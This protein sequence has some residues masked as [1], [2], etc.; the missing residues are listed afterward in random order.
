MHELVGTAES[1]GFVIVPGSDSAPYALDERRPSA[2][3]LI[4]RLL[5]DD[6][7]R[8]LYHL[9]SSPSHSRP[10]GL[11]HSITVGPQPLIGPRVGTL[12]LTERDATMLTSACLMAIGLAVDTLIAMNGWQEDV[13]ARNFHPRS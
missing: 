1:F 5:T 2:T 8:I 4:Q 9:M 7:G 3:A 6:L 10:D 13:V 11:L 12:R